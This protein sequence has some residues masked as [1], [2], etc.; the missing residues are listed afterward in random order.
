MFPINGSVF[1]ISNGTKAFSACIAAECMQMRYLI[2]NDP[3]KKNV[4]SALNEN[5]YP[6]R[7]IG[8]EGTGMF[9]Y[10][11]HRTTNDEVL[12]CMEEFFEEYGEITDIVIARTMSAVLTDGRTIAIIT[13]DSE[14]HQLIHA[15]ITEYTVKVKDKEGHEKEMYFVDYYLSKLD[16]NGSDDTDDGLSMSISRHASLADKEDLALGKHTDY[17]LD[18]EP[19]PVEYDMS[20]IERVHVP[21][22]YTTDY[23]QDESVAEEM[24]ISS[25]HVDIAFSAPDACLLFLSNSDFLMPAKFTVH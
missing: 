3:I 21:A 15:S 23:V 16:P 2:L 13:R 7:I 20:L 14:M 22:E 9:T 11:I 10:S 19:Q 17:L 8:S 4:W 5:G 6:Y 1:D 25:D 24:G 18:F 12:K